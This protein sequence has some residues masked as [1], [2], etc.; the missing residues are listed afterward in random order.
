MRL[1]CGEGGDNNDGNDRGTIAN[2]YVI[3]AERHACTVCRW[4]LKQ[5]YEQ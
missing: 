1:R 4:L 3:G 5:L 2:D